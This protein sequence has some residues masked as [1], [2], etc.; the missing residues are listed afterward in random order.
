VALSGYEQEQLE[1]LTAR[2]ERTLGHDLG[3]LDVIDIPNSE[4]VRIDGV[5]TDEDG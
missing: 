5:N 3:A 4:G 2:R 1:K